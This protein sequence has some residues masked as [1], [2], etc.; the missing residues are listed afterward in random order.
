MY[1]GHF[2]RR[3]EIIIGISALA[4]LI[5]GLTFSSIG[6]QHEQE[7]E[8]TLSLNETALIG[9][10]G[11]DGRDGVDG[12]D[13]RD[14]RNGTDGAPGA[15]GANGINGT[16][17]A[18]GPTGAAGSPGPTGQAGPTGAAGAAGTS[19]LVVGIQY[20]AHQLPQGSEGPGLTAGIWNVRTL[21]T[22][23]PGGNL[24]GVYTTLASNT[25]T[26][27]PGVYRIFGAMSMLGV[28]RN[29]PR[30]QDITNGVTLISGMST[31][32]NVQTT[33]GGIFNATSVIGV[34]LQQWVQTTSSVGQGITW[35]GSGLPNTYALLEIMRLNM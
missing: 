23:L 20:Y 4:L 30:L 33:I 2:L 7:I 25:I 26:F 9:Q 32:N 34:Q 13:G 16:N 17:G 6:Y 1:K 19:G 21:Q 10:D 24:N 28:D 8:A 27:Q 35:T 5:T 15:A 3:V 18:P 31:W 14:G 11:E 12:R 29:L 22:V